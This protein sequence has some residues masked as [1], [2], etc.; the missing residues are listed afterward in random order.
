MSTLNYPGYYIGVIIESI[1]VVIL[2]IS[3]CGDERD[4]DVV[5]LLLHR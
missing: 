4:T 5:V 1:L 3:H 2:Y